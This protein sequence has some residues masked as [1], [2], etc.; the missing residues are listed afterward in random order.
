MWKTFR[1]G[2]PQSNKSILDIYGGD[3]ENQGLYLPAIAM[4]PQGYWIHHSDG[5]T[6]AGPPGAFTPINLDKCA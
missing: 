4:K 2:T 5:F 6:G 3:L 1:L